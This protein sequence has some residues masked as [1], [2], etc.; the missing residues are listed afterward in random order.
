[1][2]ILCRLGILIAL[3]QF[4]HNDLQPSGP[5]WTFK[6]EYVLHRSYN[7]YILLHFVFS[8]QNNYDN[9]YITITLTS[10]YIYNYE[11]TYHIYMFI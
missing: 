3:L 8:K 5:C 9:V 10:T 6:A 11:L 4:Q 2:T 1:M 7:H